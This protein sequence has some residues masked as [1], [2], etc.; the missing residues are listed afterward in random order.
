[1]SDNASKLTSAT[2]WAKVSAL[3]DAEIDTSDIPPLDDAF[4]ARAKLRLPPQAELV[5]VTLHLDPQVLR[6]FQHQ[7]GEYERMIN[8]ALRIYAEA[9]S[10]NQVSDHKS[11]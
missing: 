6:W 5:E 9:H 2:D 11:A 7:G 4:F 10:Q 1:M 8:A 3:T